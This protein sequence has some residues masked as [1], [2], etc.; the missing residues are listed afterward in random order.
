MAAQH[1]LPVALIIFRRP[2]VTARAFAAVRAARPARL[3]V[4]ADGARPGVA[5]EA[6][7]VAAARA[8]TAAVDWPCAVTRL[9]ADGNMGLRA[10]VESGLHVVF[11]TEE[12]A[13]VLEDD[14][15]AEPSFFR[16]CAEL[17]DRYAGDARVMA[18]SGDNFQGGRAPGP[19]SYGFSR[20]P[21]CW[22]WATWRRAWAHYDGAMA[23]WPEL[24]AGPWLERAAGGRRAARFWRATF[25][26]VYAG[27][28]DSWAYRWTYSCWLR[29]GLTALPAHNLVSNIGVGEGATH[30]AANPF[31]ALPTRPMAFPLRH[32][33]AVVADARADART[34]RTL[35]DPG[36]PTRLAR[37]LRR[38]AGAR[39]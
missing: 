26:A 20:F 21:H 36:L 4:I 12:R 16:F 34:Q 33:P 13:V 31:A 8:A 32:P 2:E 30:T 25:D 14:C 7:R 9:Y 22:G 37:R 18:V 11:A 5:G 1:D 10:R 3:Y 29:G 35:F 38:L 27:R 19:F 15:V 39:P 6:E 28:V 23:G 17:L 24:R